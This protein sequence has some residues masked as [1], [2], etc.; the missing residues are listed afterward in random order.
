MSVLEFILGTR[1]RTS[2]D[3]FR[4]GWV[5]IPEPR[6][7][8]VHLA[9]LLMYIFKVLL[10][11]VAGVQRERERKNLKQAPC[12]VWGPT[13]GSISQPR[14]HDLGQ[15]QELDAQLTATQVLCSIMFF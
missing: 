2:G 14:D 1:P 3:S 12:P 7:S 8:Q 11:G 6:V 13:Q 10:S 4:S 15:N 5:E 9:T